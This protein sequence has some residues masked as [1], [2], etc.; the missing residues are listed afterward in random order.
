MELY[1][2][3]KV[4]CCLWWLIM[5]KTTSAGRYPYCS[6]GCCPHEFCAFR[7]ICYPVLHCSDGCPDG[8]CQNG[9]CM[10]DKLCHKS[11]ECKLGDICTMN[12]NIGYKTCQYDLDIGKSLC[13]DRDGKPNVKKY[14]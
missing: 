14:P 12:Y 1:K 2:M 4:L 13:V 8:S 6:E 5:L 10:P 3:R 11:A 7:S 9:L